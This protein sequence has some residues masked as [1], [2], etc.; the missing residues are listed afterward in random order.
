MFLVDPQNPI[1]STANVPPQR[2]DWWA[3]L[4]QTEGLLRTREGRRLPPELENQTFAMID[5]FPISWERAL[6]IREYFMRERMGIDES[7]DETIH[8]YTYSYCEH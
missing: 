8:E 1:V 5:D 3:E 6:E 4:V 2:R 7:H